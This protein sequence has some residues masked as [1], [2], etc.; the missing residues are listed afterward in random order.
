MRRFVAKLWDGEEWWV[1]SL[2]S[3]IPLVF[4]AIS[5]LVYIPGGNW[6]YASFGCLAFTL[7]LVALSVGVFICKA[8]NLGLAGWRTTLGG[9]FAYVLAAG[10]PLLLFRIA[11]RSWVMTHG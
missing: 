10:I 9:F 11:F 4:L 2:L 7:L 5:Y 3:F 8:V 1:F 6:Y